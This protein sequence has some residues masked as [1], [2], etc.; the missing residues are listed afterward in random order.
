M[1]GPRVAASPHDRHLS[2]KLEVGPRR[3][4]KASARASSRTGIRS[5]WTEPS[6]GRDDPDRGVILGGYLDRSKIGQHPRRSVRPPRIVGAGRPAP[7]KSE[8]GNNGHFKLD[9]RKHRRARCA[10]EGSTTAGRA[11][12][13]GPLGRVKWMDSLYEGREL[14]DGEVELGV[15][16]TVDQAF[17][18]RPS[19]RTDAPLTVRPIRAAMSEEL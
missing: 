18:S 12:A 5:C 10:P 15:D 19:R 1:R 6:R 3:S 7:R 16:P 8:I 13:P 11:S 17:L 14:R 2:A 9:S 4:R